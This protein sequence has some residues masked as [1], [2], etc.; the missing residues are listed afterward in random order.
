MCG[1]LSVLIQHFGS[2]EAGGAFAAL[3]MCPFAEAFDRMVW[4]FRRRGV[5]Y[6]TVKKE[7]QKRLSRRI[8]TR[9][10]QEWAALEEEHE[11]D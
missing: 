10:E 1:V 7:L 3:I 11:L 2:V 9:P 4:Y 6:Q 5:S 8:K